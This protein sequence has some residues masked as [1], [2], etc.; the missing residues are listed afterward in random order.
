MRSQI[1]ERRVNNQCRDWKV[2]KRRTKK[3][4]NRQRLD[5]HQ[6]GQRF[7]Q[8]ENVQWYYGAA[9]QGRWHR[10]RNM[11]MDTAER[12]RD[13]KKGDAVNSFARI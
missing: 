7:R 4:E 10:K 11:E 9:T 1:D 5:K 6:R 8:G 3:W 2:N 13:K 12:K